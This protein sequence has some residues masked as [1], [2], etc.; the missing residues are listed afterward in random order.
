MTAGFAPASVLSPTRPRRT[1]VVVVLAVYALTRLFDAVLISRAAGRQLPSIWTGA[2]SGY[3]DMARLWDAQ[4]YQII[5][6]TGYPLP[7]PIDASG[8]VQQNPWAFFPGFPYTVRA[9][10]ALTSLPFS[11]AAVLLNVVLGAGAVVVLLRLLQRVAGRRAAVGAVV[12]VCA[13]PSA[14]VLQI[15]YSETLALLL[16]L[17]AMLWLLSRRYRLTAVAVL[18]LSLTRPV[19]APFAV[20]VLAHLV[21]RWRARASDPLARRDVAQIVALGL[22]SAVATFIWPAMVALITGVPSAYT[23]IQGAWRT[24]GVV[25]TPYEGTLFISHVLWG[26]D[27]PLWVAAAAVALVALVLSP[28]AR[29]MGTELRTWV[30]AY[31]AYLLAVIEPY[32]S[33]YRYAIF[34][35]P[36]L[37]LPGAV[38]RVGPL[39]VVLLAVAGLAYQ[40]RWVDQLLVF[41]PPTDYPP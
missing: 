14:P 28:L 8:A 29:P 27:G 23:R 37:V 19:V 4:W 32:T 7:L 39:L 18:A 5:A 10:M 21:L 33:T 38:R 13:F 30:L 1:D 24:G 12:L 31:P 22:F 17:L 41:T 9:V 6:T 2:H 35:F 20:M 11:P 15:G 34:V 26:D 36:L 3:F 40:V 25:A 16:L